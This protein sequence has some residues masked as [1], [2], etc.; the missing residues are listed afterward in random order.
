M[1]HIVC[2]VSFEN[3]SNCVYVYMFPERHVTMLHIRSSIFKLNQI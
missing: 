2:I 3:E 1:L